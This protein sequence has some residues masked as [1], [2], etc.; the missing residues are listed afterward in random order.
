MKNGRNIFLYILLLVTVLFFSEINAHSNPEKQRYYLEHA[1]GINNFENLISHHTDISEEDQM[2]QSH[3][4]LLQEQ[5]ECQQ[6]DVCNLP[7][8][9]SLLVSVWQPPK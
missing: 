6:S 7:L 8:I 9:S 3:L 5:P 1:S 4:I 2:E